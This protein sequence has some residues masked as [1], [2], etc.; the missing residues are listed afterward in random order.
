MALLSKSAILHLLYQGQSTAHRLALF[1]P[2]TYQ[3]LKESM[4]A[5]GLG[6]ELPRWIDEPLAPGYA[7]DKAGRAAALARD[8]D[9]GFDPAD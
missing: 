8:D 2:E 9:A 5:L 4:V 6:D 3:D 1:E 7:D